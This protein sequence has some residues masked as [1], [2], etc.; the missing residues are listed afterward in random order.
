M[1]TLNISPETKI[2]KLENWNL[3]DF[4]KG[5]K[6]TYTLMRDEK[7]RGKFDEKE[8]KDFI[9]NT[10]S[11]NTSNGVVYRTDKK[12]LILVILT[13]WFEQRVEY[14]KLFKKLSDEGDDEKYNYFNRRQYLQKVLLNSIYGVLGLSV[15]R[16]YDTDN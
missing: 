8:L 11:F 5:G 12:G 14:R 15:F 10:P 2:G 13:K 3:E 7:V 4:I 6:K 1:R 9:D 16:F